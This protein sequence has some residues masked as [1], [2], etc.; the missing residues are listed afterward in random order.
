MPTD[1]DV[2]Q[3]VLKMLSIFVNMPE[4]SIKDEYVLTKTPLLMDPTKL[5]FF[6]L[7]L[8]G[9]VKSINADQTVTSAEVS[10]PGLTV[11]GLVALIQAKVR[12]T[13]RR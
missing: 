6:A 12:R 5:N 8:R 4:S 10:A 9:Y 2:K 11:A 7:S 1:A 13:V 3:N